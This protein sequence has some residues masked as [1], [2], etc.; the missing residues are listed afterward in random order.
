[1]RESRK[2]SRKN[3]KEQENEAGFS[4]RVFTRYFRP[5]EIIL[6]NKAKA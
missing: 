3:E 5:K 2:K 1:M 6:R 4:Q